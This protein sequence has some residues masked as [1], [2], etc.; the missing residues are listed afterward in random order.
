MNLL[1]PKW[2]TAD[3]LAK[4]WGVDINKI[5][6]YNLSGQLIA[7]LIIKKIDSAGTLFYPENYEVNKVMLYLN[8]LKYIDKCYKLEEVERFEKKYGINPNYDQEEYPL[9]EKPQNNNTT[10]LAQTNSYINDIISKIT[11][12][13]ENDDSITIQQKGKPQEVVN[14]TSLKFQPGSKR[15]TWNNFLTILQS[16]PYYYWKTAE[17]PLNQLKEIDAKLHYWMENNFGIIFTKSYRLFER[18]KGKGRGIYRF[19]FNV[20]ECQINENIKKNFRE[21]FFNIIEFNKDNLNN[22]FQQIKDMAAEG[23]IKKYLTNKE[24]IDALNTN[25]ENNSNKIFEDNLTVTKKP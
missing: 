4:D 22:V 7:K 1:R 3:A 15:L 24:V 2:Y 21:K 25:P 12:R 5:H 17:R 11:I 16:P 19:K 14:L 20:G 13:Y 8:G 10:K 9:V 6:S 23:L 18:V